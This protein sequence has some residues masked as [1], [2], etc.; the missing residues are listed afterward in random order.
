M[1]RTLPASITTTTTAATAAAA[2][3]TGLATAPAA[4][5]DLLIEVRGV[6]SDA[7]QL[8]V[9]VHT[10]RK[11][12]KFP[13]TKGMFAGLTRRA[14][15]GDV[16]FVLQGVPPGAYAVNAFH[17]ENGNG[18]LDTNLLGI[19][20]EGYAFANDPPSRF[21]P[22]DFEEA[23]VTVGDAPAAATLTMSY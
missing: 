15:E 7:G 17:D 14:Q 5:A 1:F 23:A 18:D 19:P 16:R 20:K 11:G 21:G 6:R 13:Y 3:L 10:P 8:F 22:P 4:A 2:I 12:E 9:A